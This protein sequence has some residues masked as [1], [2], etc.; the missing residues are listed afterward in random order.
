MD[1]LKEIADIKTSIYEPNKEILEQEFDWFLKCAIKDL[2]YKLRFET[3]KKHILKTARMEF[4]ENFIRCRYMGDGGLNFTAFYV[5]EDKMEY[6]RNR[7]REIINLFDPNDDF[8]F[9]ADC[10]SDEVTRE[11]YSIKNEE[12]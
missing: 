6:T 11:H 2:A 9:H 8:D 10:K 7:I 4:P 5:P 1:M 12:A 3:A